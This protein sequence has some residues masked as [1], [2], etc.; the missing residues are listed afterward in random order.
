MKRDGSFSVGEPDFATPQH[1][2]EN[3]IGASPNEVIVTPG[4]KQAILFD[5]AW[6]SYESCVKQER[7]N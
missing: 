3:D 2:I 5:P 7:R 4:A 1:I 6:V